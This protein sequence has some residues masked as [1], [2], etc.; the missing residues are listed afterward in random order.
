MNPRLI[1]V[2]V[3]IFGICLSNSEEASRSIPE[4]TLLHSKYEAAV[5]SQVQKTMKP[6]ENLFKNYEARIE[7]LIDNFQKLGNLEGV[8]AARNAIELEPKTSNINTKFEDISKLQKI[9]ISEKKKIIDLDNKA[10][11][12]LLKKY[13]TALDALKKKITQEGRIDDAVYLDKFIKEINNSNSVSEPSEVVVNPDQPS[14][15]TS[16]FEFEKVGNGVVLKKY[17]GKSE[18]VVVPSE[19]EEKKITVIGIKAFDHKKMESIKLPDSVVEIQESAFSGCY[20]RRIQLP[21]SLKIIGQN[22]FHWNDFGNIKLPTGLQKID[23]RA[24]NYCRML[25]SIEIPTTVTELGQLA[26]LGCES[27]EKVTLSEAI[28][29]IKIGTF[30]NTKIKN[31]VLPEKVEIIERGAFSRCENLESVKINGVK[32]IEDEAFTTSGDFKLI[33]NTPP[34]K[35]LGKNVF[36]GSSPIIERPFGLSG[37]GDEWAGFKV[38]VIR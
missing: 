3:L 17:W 5:E 1:F 16:D 36:R 21:K 26:F 27:L 25:S 9:F 30:Q 8:V 22:A 38:N 6:L 20:L 19:Y 23:D 2:L 33:F 7:I 29:I 37:W 10:Q 31:I 32:R 28:D 13:L 35:F 11:D 15:P 18:N 24:F 34:P 12:V 4:L 14:S